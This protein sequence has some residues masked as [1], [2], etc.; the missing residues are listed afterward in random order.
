MHNFEIWG[1][2]RY[3]KKSLGRDEGGA[4]TGLLRQRKDQFREK[5]T[6]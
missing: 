2:E 4:H 1:P 5:L 6:V 3:K